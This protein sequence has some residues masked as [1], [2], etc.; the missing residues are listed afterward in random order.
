MRN[1]IVALLIGPILFG[2]LSDKNGSLTESNDSGSG[3]DQSGNSAPT[4]SGNPLSDILFGESYDFLPNAADADGDVLTFTVQN[5]PAWATFDASTGRLTGLPTLGD[6]GIYNNITIGVS[7][8]KASDFLPSYTLSV[9]QSA[10]GSV[11]LSWTAPTENSDGSTLIDL[12]G[13]KIY[14]GRNPGNYDQDIRID[15]PSVLT[16]V[17]EQLSSGTYYFSATAFNSAGIE[18]AFSGEAVRTLN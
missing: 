17:V 3:D 7:D 18:S 10:L 13:Y 16:Y 8:G 2:C 11:T 4:I 9:N 14:Y 15:N 1:I 6:V 5:R 12:A